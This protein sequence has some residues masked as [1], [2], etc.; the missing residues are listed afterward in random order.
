MTLRLSS[1]ETATTARLV[2]PDFFIRDLE[3]ETAVKPP[4][5]GMIVDSLGQ[6]DAVLKASSWKIAYKTR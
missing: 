6:S 4:T 2:L 5:L 1:G 3:K